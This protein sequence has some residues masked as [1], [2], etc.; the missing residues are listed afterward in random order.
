MLFM[1]LKQFTKESV[2]KVKKYLKY[3]KDTDWTEIEVYYPGSDPG[4]RRINYEETIK[5][6]KSEYLVQDKMALFA[7]NRIKTLTTRYKDFKRESV[8]KTFIKNA[9]SMI[10][11]HV[12]RSQNYEIKIDV[13]EIENPD[14]KSTEMSF[15]QMVTDK[16]TA[17]TDKVT[18]LDLSTDDNSTTFE[19]FNG[20]RA[21]LVMHYVLVN[22]Y[23][24]IGRILKEKKIDF[25]SEPEPTIFILDENPPQWDPER[26]YFDQDR[27]TL[28]YYVDEW[29][30][31]RRGIVIDDTY[32]SPWMYYH[33]NFFVT[34]YP[35]TFLNEMTGEEENKDV[36]GVPPLRDNEWFVISANYEEA[37]P[38]LL[39]RLVGQGSLLCK[40]LT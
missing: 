2:N 10:D 40:H 32:I 34:K 13:L 21:P 35:T 5:Q 4:R 20:M 36:V 11:Y 8:Y 16:Y 27:D 14:D 22:L 38:I 31:C 19:L 29:K 24:Q 26:H 23:P 15:Q 37:H 30:K 28:Q 12:E 6:R 9:I 3:I 1:E 18:S 17:I 39:L 33:M 7:V 25:D